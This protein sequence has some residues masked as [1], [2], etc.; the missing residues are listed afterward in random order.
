MD[1]KIRVTDEQGGIIM[2]VNIWV[3]VFVCAS[4]HRFSIPLG[5]IRVFIDDI[6]ISK[7]QWFEED[8]ERG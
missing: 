1:G 7:P 4:S 6:E 3:M 8:G 5:D 2:A